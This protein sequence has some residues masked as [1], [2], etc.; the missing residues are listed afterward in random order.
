MEISVRAGLGHI[1]NVLHPHALIT[2][3][4]NG[5]ELFFRNAIKWM[6]R[7]VDI[8]HIGLP[9]RASN[10]MWISTLDGSSLEGATHSLS[11]FELTSADPYR[12]PGIRSR[13]NCS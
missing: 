11:S 1:Y 4:G 13:W 12:K 6:T 9:T 10:F 2:R 5:E 7:Q 3:D 8:P